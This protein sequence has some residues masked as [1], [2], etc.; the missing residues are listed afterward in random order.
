MYH[1]K[2]DRRSLQSSEMMYE[3]LIA[4]IKEKSYQD[5]TVT[6]IVTRANL[7][8][9]TFY[10]NFDAI[11]DILEWKCDEAFVGFYEY[12]LEYDKTL[13][14]MH[15]REPGS[16]F[17]PFLRYWYTKSLII[18]ILYKVGRSEIVNRSFERMFERNAPAVQNL[19]ATIEQ[20]F[21][22]FVAIRRG[23][24]LSILEQWI[25]NGKDIPPDELAAL[26]TELIRLSI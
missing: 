11:D 8:R 14:V 18:E 20:Y 15:D 23:V 4:L 1:I 16:L 17:K 7:G 24:A 9:A 25:K 10:R 2:N 26:I 22:Y 19:N 3:A 6:E 21:G 12:L 5:L 13:G